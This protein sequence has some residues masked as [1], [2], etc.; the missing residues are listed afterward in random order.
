MPNRLHAKSQQPDASEK[1]YGP[2]AV[3]LRVVS[4]ETVRKI[5]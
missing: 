2:P 3:R 1:I 5:D 4:H